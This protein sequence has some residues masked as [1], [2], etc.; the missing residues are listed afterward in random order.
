M[1]GMKS[2][3]LYKIV[4]YAGCCCAL[5]GVRASLLAAP[6]KHRITFMSRPS[7]HPGIIAQVQNSP[8]L[9]TA[10]GRGSISVNSIFDFGAPPQGDLYLN[11]KWNLTRSSGTDTSRW[12]TPL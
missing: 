4:G 10:N 1:L 7:S 11:L 9:F 6:A 12:F 3:C 5:C 8:G 2:Y